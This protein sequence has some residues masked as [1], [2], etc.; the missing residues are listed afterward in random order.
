M[1]RSRFLPRTLTLL[2]AVCLLWPVQFSA[3]ATCGTGDSGSIDLVVDALACNG[4]SGES[5]A[6]AVFHR[7]LAKLSGNADLGLPS[8]V[9][10]Y[11]TLTFADGRSTCSVDWL[12][13]PPRDPPKTLR[14]CTLLI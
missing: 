12:R 5:S 11:V 10:P 7:D 13:P 14:F 9:R 2:I 1:R 8:L 6:A 4:D 3:A